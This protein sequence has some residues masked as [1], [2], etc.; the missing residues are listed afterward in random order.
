MARLVHYTVREYPLTHTAISSGARFEIAKACLQYLTLDVSDANSS[1]LV[2]V[3]L[4][5][6]RLV[7]GYV[8]INWEYHMRL[9]EEPD[10]LV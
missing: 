2:K 10:D 7:I 5:L 8:A 6:K 3:E 4:Y 9:A 1:P